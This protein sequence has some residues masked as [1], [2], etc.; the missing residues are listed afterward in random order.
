MFDALILSTDTWST[1]EDTTLFEVVHKIGAFNWS[2][3]S[4][5]LPCRTARQ[6]RERWH[7]HLNIG[8]RKV[9]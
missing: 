5:L 4:A 7:N 2:A 3:I 9:I 1:Q 6:C 8:F